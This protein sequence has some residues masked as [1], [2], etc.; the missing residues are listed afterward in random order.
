MNQEQK[1]QVKMKKNRSKDQKEKR[2]DQMKM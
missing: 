2:L 1:I